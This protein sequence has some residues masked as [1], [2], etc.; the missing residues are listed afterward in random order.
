MAIRRKTVY[1]PLMRV[2]ETFVWENGVSS[3]T[4]STSDDL[5]QAGASVRAPFIVEEHIIGSNDKTSKYTFIIQ[6]RN[7]AMGTITLLAEEET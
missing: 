1:F 3:S 6:R 7:S 4:G 2:S 5:D